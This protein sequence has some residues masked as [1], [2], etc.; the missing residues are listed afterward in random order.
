M[1]LKLT[2]GLSQKIG[3]PHYGSLGASCHVE[4]ELD[5][6]LLFQNPDGWQEKIRQ[7][8]DACRWAVQAELRSGKEDAELIGRP[9]PGCH[10]IDQ[11]V[12]TPAP[13]SSRAVQSP[14]LATASQVRAIESIAQRQELDLAGVLR[15]QFGIEQASGLSRQEASRLIDQLQSVVDASA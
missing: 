15:S 12:V 3:L 5:Q 4:L 2:C 8:F 14:R 9:E 13:R 10:A 11:E 7:I 1:P 6:S